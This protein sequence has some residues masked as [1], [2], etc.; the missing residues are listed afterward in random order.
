VARDLA[1]VAA[2]ADEA[3]AFPEDLAEL[4]LAAAKRPPSAWVASLRSIERALA[5]LRRN[6]SPE[7]LLDAVALRWS[8]A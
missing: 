7:L 1:V 8:R 5:A 3:A 4:R 6:A 2:G